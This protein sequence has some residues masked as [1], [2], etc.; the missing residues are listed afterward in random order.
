MTTPVATQPAV[1]PP[2]Q[3]APVQESFAE[4]FPTAYATDYIMSV[5]KR[6]NMPVSMI[7]GKLAETVKQMASE[8]GVYLV[9]MHGASVQYMQN[10]D[11][12]GNAMRINVGVK[13]I[14]G[15]AQPVNP[16]SAKPGLGI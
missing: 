15:S 8:N 7:K 9:K 1:T 2:V 12:Q 5:M 6:L 10:S 11:A 3:T 14:P 4:V 13:K 16:G